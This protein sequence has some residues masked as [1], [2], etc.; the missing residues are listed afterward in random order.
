M[1]TTQSDQTDPA[2]TPSASY[3][4]P[5][6]TSPGRAF[7]IGGAICAVVAIVFLP[8][9]LGPVGAVLGFVGYSKGDKAGLWVGVFAIVA[10]FAGIMLGLAVFHHARSVRRY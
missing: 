8:I 10:T 5:S 6:T 2:P 1:A 7:T 4:A 3:P 9:I